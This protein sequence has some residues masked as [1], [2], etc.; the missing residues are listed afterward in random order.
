MLEKERQK[1]KGEIQKNIAEFSGET[2]WKRTPH[3]SVIEMGT[4]FCNEL[5]D[6]TETLDQ[7]NKIS[8]VSLF[9]NVVLVLVAETSAYEGISDDE[10]EA[11]EKLFDELRVLKDE[12][13]KN[14]LTDYMF[15]KIMY[16]RELFLTNTVCREDYDCKYRQ[17]MPFPNFVDLYE[18]VHKI[19]VNW[20][21]LVKDKDFRRKKV[22]FF[23]FRHFDC[24]D[25]GKEREFAR[26]F[27]NMLD[28]ILG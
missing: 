13:L 4:K 2:R 6:L 25:T 8:H 9:S 7:E 10:L 5:I 19:N 22:D 23:E 28:E 11:F 1:A 3:S 18:I 15:E 24:T 27:L 16:I 26:E 20:D 21:N 17:G 14:G 12:F